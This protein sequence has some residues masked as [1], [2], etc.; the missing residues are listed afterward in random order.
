MGARKYFDESRKEN[1]YK[2]VT[3]TNY[4]TLAKKGVRL[5]KFFMVLED[6]I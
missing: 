4:K 5:S 1:R 3:T 6:N 2:N